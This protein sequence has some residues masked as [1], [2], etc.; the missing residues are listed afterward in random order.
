MGEM[1][2]GATQVERHW[3]AQQKRPRKA[4]RPGPSPSLS[5]SLCP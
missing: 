5:L 3:S 1:L 4:E 2:G